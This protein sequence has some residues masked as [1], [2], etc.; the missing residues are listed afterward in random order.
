MNWTFLLILVLGIAIWFA[1]RQMAFVQARTAL[2]HLKQGAKVIDVRNPDEYAARHVRPAINIPLSELDRRI[3]EVAPDKNTILL[4]HCQGGVRSGMAK[5]QLERMG[6][7]Q[8]FNL[9]SYG[10]AERILKES[11]GGK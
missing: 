2:H 4:L 3:T 6:Y 10:R 5:R 8:V 11:G 9:G 1:L 7:R